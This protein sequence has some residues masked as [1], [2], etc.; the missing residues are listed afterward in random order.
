[1]SLVAVLVGLVLIS[2]NGA[3][4]AFEFGVLGAK[5]AVIDAGVAS[6]ERSSIAAHRLQSDVLLSLGGAQLGITICAIVLGK[7]MEPALSEVIENLIN[8]FFEISETLLHSIGFAVALALVV[9]IHMVMGE[10]VPK[11]LALAGPEKTLLYLSRPMSGYLL[12]ARPV[13]RA[14]LWLSN[15]LLTVLR[16]KPTRELSEVVTAAELGLMVRDSH[17]EGLID[18][19]ERSLIESALQFSNTSVLEVMMPFEKVN[20]VHLNAQLTDIET[21]FDETQHTRLVVVGQDSNDVRG[22]VHGKDLLQLPLD[23]LSGKLEASSI[24]PMLRISGQSN[25]PEVLQLMQKSR[26]H[27]ALVTDDRTSLG[28]VTLDD[29][30][31]GL[32]GR[33][34]EDIDHSAED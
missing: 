1:M 6:G 23:E 18:A 13:V 31:R 15:G 30:M 28:V 3:F 29:V 34:S 19:E 2:F 14:L 8:R 10:M 4:V 11:N 32:I 7:L 27:L 22:F 16:V 12:L 17:Q 20:F 25:L 5:R 33:L 9:L 24:R 26:V 21:C